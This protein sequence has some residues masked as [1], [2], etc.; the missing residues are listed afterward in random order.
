MSTWGLAST[1]PLVDFAEDPEDL[2]YKYLGANWAITTPSHL[3]KLAL[4]QTETPASMVNR[5]EPGNRPIWIWCQHY[6]LNSER[7]LFG[8]T[9]GKHGL[10]QH[11]HTFNIHLLS[12]RLTQD[13]DISRPGHTFQRNRTA[14]IP[15]HCISNNRNRPVHFISYATCD[16]SNGYGGSL[17]RNLQGNLSIYCTIPQTFSSLSLNLNLI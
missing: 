5:P 11:N 8:S 13:P 6:D 1:T 16:G 3:T 9:I 7:S 10:V 12:R 4:F 2:V 17:C 15:I 14:A